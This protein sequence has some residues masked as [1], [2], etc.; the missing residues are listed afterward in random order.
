MWCE[1]DKPSDNG[2]YLDYE[3]GKCRKRL[4]DNVVEE[5]IENIDENKM[6]YNGTLNGHKNV[7]GSCER[8]SCVHLKTVKYIALYSSQYTLYYSLYV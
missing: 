7:Y 3:N 2:E 6:I 1:C 5:C 4:I 8:S